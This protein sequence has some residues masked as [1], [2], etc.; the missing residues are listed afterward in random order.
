M[1][2]ASEVFLDRALE[3]YRGAVKAWSRD[4]LLST[5]ALAVAALFVVAPY[6]RLDRQGRD[7]ED[8]RAQAQAEHD[9]VQAVLSELDGLTAS[10]SATKSALADT[11]E[12]LAEDLAARVRRFAALADQLRAAP[13]PP[14]I[15]P[16]DTEP[17]FPAMLQVAPSPMQAPDPAFPPGPIGRQMDLPALE[18]LPPEE[19][20]A[21]FGL[22]HTSVAT[23]RAA[24]V[25]G[26]GSAAWKEAS[27]LSLRVFKSEIEAAYGHL[28]EEVKTRLDTLAST[29]IASL[30]RARPSAERLGLTLPTASE[31]APEAAV[32]R[33]PPDDR[34]F[35]T[36]AGKVEAFRV[37]GL[38]EV[39]LDL[40]A[41]EAP[42]RAVAEDLVETS[43]TLEQE[44]TRLEALQAEIS[45]ELR[46]LDQRLDTIAAELGTLGAPLKWLAIDSG[47]FVALYPTLFALAFA[48]LA[49]RSARLHG[50][51]R[52][53]RAGYGAIGVPDADI[54]LALYVPDGFFA[55]TGQ[56]ALARVLL[57]AAFIGGIA[58]VALW[59]Q[60]S[61]GAWVWQVPALL[62]GVIGGAALVR[63]GMFDGLAGR[64]SEEAGGQQPGQ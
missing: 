62:L 33:L 17:A 21:E 15:V 26:P 49:V 8:R 2:A 23:F 32:I 4:A 47:R 39:Q 58:A 22:D 18:P 11:A 46:T 16:P 28:E 37:V 13:Q 52:Y 51:E 34:L 59:V 25:D 7:V 6:L 24:F 60:D 61:D 19:A 9:D 54:R 30:E 29:I 5:V 64:R 48:W 40:G 10:I 27:E 41:A 63:P 14:D 57:A 55:G 31:L 38:Y 12:R 36:V 42:L 35:G 43:T 45:S 20:L 3:A 1:T 53:L 44:R 56:S 50:L